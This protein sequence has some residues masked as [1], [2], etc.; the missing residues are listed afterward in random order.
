MSCIEQKA[1]RIIRN[2][3][4]ATAVDALS[5]AIIMNLA[6]PV[7]DILKHIRTVDFTKSRTKQTVSLFETTIRYLGGMLSAYDLLNEDS[8]KGLVRNVSC[9]YYLS[10]LANLV[11]TMI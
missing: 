3:W 6:D 9:P 4:G 8:R 10:H 2:G 7:N 1:N 11:R 5:T